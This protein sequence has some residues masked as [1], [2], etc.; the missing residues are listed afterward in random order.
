MV[1][2][3]PV[4]SGFAVTHFARCL[5]DLAVWWGGAWFSSLKAPS[6][7][8]GA[9]GEQRAHGALGTGGALGA[10]HGAGGAE[11]LAGAGPAAPSLR[12]HFAPG[13]LIS[14]RLP[15]RGQLPLL[16]S[17]MNQQEALPGLERFYLKSQ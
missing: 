4:A 1:A 9:Q 8:L 3:F 5:S 14:A 2:A 6:P 15:L 7:H 13:Y 10:D 17:Q 12:G 16:C 11:V